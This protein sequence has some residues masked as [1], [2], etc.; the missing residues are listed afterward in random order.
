MKARGPPGPQLTLFLPSAIIGRIVRT[1]FPST[2]KSHTTRFAAPKFLYLLACLAIGLAA[3]ILLP[4]G[5]AYSQGQAPAPADVDA[6]K[7]QPLD[8]KPGCW[9]V[10]THVS[11]AGSPILTADEIAATLTPGQR[12]ALTPEQ[13]AQMTASVQ[14]SEKFGAQLAEKGSGTLGVVCT[15]AP[16]VDVGVE[17]YGTELYG[18]PGAANR[19]TRSI[20][21]SGEKRNI[22]VACPTIEGNASSGRLPTRI[23]DEYERLDSED[24][25]GTQHRVSDLGNGRT[26]DDTTTVIVGKW[27]GDAAPHL[28]HSPAPTGINGK[29]V[30]GPLAVAWLDPFR[31]V[32]TIGGRQFLAAQT[33][34]L[35]HFVTP[36]AAK[37]YGPQL[38]DVFQKIC[39]HAGVA[40]EALLLHLDIQ[41]PWQKQLEN[42]G[43][44]NQTFAPFGSIVAPQGPQNPFDFH[45]IWAVNAALAVPATWTD[46]HLEIA[47]SSSVGHQAAVDIFWNAYFS[48]AKTDAEKQA[49]LHKV[50]ETYKITVIDPDFFNGQTSP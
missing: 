48:Q 10:A 20:E 43:Y 49:L 8:L 18:I 23:T 2:A 45:A 40:R 27:T 5:P 37:E 26:Q 13:L 12:A 22:H 24:F 3:T 11:V 7:V 19:C 32:A 41:Q 46:F 15:G 9:Q 16:F 14:A 34:V 33:Y 39:M 44:S 25:R 38:P 42:A 35:L 4:T 50:Q 6:G 17:V 21:V 28:P 47:R 36:R 31:I 1:R 29:K 30:L